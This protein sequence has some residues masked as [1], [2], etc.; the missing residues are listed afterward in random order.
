MRDIMGIVDHMIKNGST[1]AGN[2]GMDSLIE[3]LA[4]TM[5]PVSLEIIGE[6]VRITPNSQSGIDYLNTLLSGVDYSHAIIDGN[7]IILPIDDPIY[8]Q[9]VLKYS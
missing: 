4:E 2:Y 3:A 8:L 9:L 6:T 7:S 1:A 5:K